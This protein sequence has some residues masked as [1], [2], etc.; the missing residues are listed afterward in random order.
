M[1]TEPREP[2]RV[3]Q[4]IERSIP[5]QQTKDASVH[6]NTPN[7]RS[8][9]TSNRR[10]TACEFIA[11]LQS[12]VTNHENFTET[13]DAESAATVHDISG[14]LHFHARQSIYTVHRYLELLPRTKLTGRFAPV[15]I[16]CNLLHS[17]YAFDPSFSRRHFGRW[18]ERSI[19]Q[20]HRGSRW[21][22]QQSDELR[23]PLGAFSSSVQS[24]HGL[25]SHIPQEC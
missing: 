14:Y 15:K 17:V 13:Q 3:R 23:E 11:T 12:L 19:S 16:R 4:N 22:E 20:P 1:I 5:V 10:L 25:F 8:C 9:G 21:T 7:P 24:W 18:N 6:D 2:Q